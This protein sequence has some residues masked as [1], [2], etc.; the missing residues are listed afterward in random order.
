VVV[1]AVDPDVAN[2]DWRD[3]YHNGYI[4]GI[5]IVVGFLDHI[6]EISPEGREA[7]WTKELADALRLAAANIPPR[8]RGDE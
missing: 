7:D 5:G 3:G 6:S 1:A 4:Q 2:T 8:P